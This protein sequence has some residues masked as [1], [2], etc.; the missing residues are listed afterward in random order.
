[1]DE[2]LMSE[3]DFMP[4]H[5]WQP[6]TPRG[7]AAFAL[8]PLGRLL[9]VQLVVAAFT[10][11]LLV[12]LVASNWLPVAREAIAGLPPGAAVRDGLLRWTTNTPVRLAENRFL[13]LVVD[14]RD[15]GRLGRVAD[16]E[17][18]LHDT[19]F[20]VASLFGYAQFRYPAAGWVLSLD[21]AEVVPWWGAW[22]LPLLAMLGAGAMLGLMAIWFVLATVYCLGA[23]ALGL[24]ANRK[25]GVRASWKLGGA[26]LMPGALVLDL[27]LFSYGALGMDLIR[28]GLFFLLHLVAGWVYLGLS[29]YFLPRAAE[30]DAVSGNPF[31]PPGQPENPPASR[32]QN[33]FAPPR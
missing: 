28:L 32:E 19:H 16:L 31:A 7:V 25:L 18:A 17:V 13:A 23:W 9:L 24:L 4:R 27:G 5:A 26:A 10:A 22:E 3:T 20:T 8:A 30:A 21:S 29:P 12:W 15:T 1:L 11:A 2:G 6:F 33:P 14:A